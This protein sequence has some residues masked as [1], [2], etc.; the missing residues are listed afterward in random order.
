[1]IDFCDDFKDLT[2]ELFGEKWIVLEAEK[3][4]LKRRREELG[5]T[6]QQ[7]A[8]KAQILLRQ[9]QRL[10]SEDRGIASASL[11]IGLSVC[12]ALKLDPRRFVPA[13]WDM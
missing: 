7:V 4:M 2:D 12:A 6:Q 9:Y 11:R 10:E 5:M 13:T 3:S 8:D 1:M